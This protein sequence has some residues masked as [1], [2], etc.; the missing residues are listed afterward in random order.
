MIRVSIVKTH[1]HM[2]AALGVALGV[3]KPDILKALRPDHPLS[4]RMYYWY[5]RRQRYLEKRHR[6]WLEKLADKV[7]NYSDKRPMLTVIHN[8]VEPDYVMIKKAKRRT[9]QA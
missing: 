7:V 6:L 4:D 2:V 3:S 5:I 1:R 9:I 8:A